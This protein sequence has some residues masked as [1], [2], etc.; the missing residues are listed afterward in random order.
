MDG[1]MTVGIAEPTTD[2][3]RIASVYAL[4]PADGCRSRTGKVQIEL[5]PD[6]EGRTMILV[7]IDE[8]ARGVELPYE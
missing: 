4:P 2:G 3:F 7:S 5:K 8:E 1:E 6:E